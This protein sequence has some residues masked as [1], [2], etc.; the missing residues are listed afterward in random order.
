MKWQSDKRRV[1]WVVGASSGIGLALTEQL[2]E[3]GNK[4]IASSRKEASLMKFYARYPERFHFVRC[5]V[6][7]M[8][9][10]Q[11]AVAQIDEADHL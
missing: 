7:Q 9:N 2:L 11:Q 5:D 1:V 8:E 4:V 3:Q 6:T 10:V